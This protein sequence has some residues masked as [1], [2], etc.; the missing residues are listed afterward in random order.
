MSGADDKLMKPRALMNDP[1][2]TAGER[3]AA[4]KA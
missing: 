1:A 3:A 2:A 4:R